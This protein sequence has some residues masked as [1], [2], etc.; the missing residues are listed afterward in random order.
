MLS[1]LAACQPTLNWR[2]VRPTGSGAV[3]LFPCKPDI[4]QRPAHAGQGAMGLAQCEAGGGRFALSWA[5]GPDPTQAGPALK[6][7]PQAL[8]TKLG[9]PLPPAQPLLVPGMTPLP[10]AAEYRLTGAGGITRVAVFAHGG[11][12]YQALMTLPQDD[13]AAWE[14][15]RAGLAMETAR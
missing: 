9:Q 7:M 14:S 12:V 6:A 5:D 15:F 8:A 11:R 2:E 1:L 10:E 13:P 3:A 4:E